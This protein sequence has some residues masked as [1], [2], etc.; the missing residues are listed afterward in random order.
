M[1]QDRTL[2]FLADPATH[3]LPPGASVKIIETHVSWVF[4]AGEQAFKLKKQVRFPYLD[5]TGL[6]DRQR[7]CEAELRINR[8]TAPDLYLGLRRVTETTEGALE[9]DGAGPVVDWLVG[10]RRFAD[11]A[12]FIDLAADGRLRRRLTEDLAD[13]IAEFHGAADYSPEWGGSTRIRAIVDNNDTSFRQLAEG[14]LAACFTP[15]AIDQLTAG[16]RVWLERVS[17]LLDAR[18]DAGR[19]RHCHGDLHLANICLYEGRPTPF[20][21]IEFSDLFARIDVFYD[22]AFLLMDLDHRGFRRLAAFVL[23]RYLDQGGPP[24]DPDAGDARPGD[25][26]AGLAALP[27]FLSMRAAV[28]AHVSGAQAAGLADPATRAGRQAEAGAYF[29]RALSYLDVPAPRLVAVGGLSGSGKSRLARELASHLGAAPGARVVRSD[30]T[31]KRL[32]GIDIQDRLAPEF[33]TPEWSARTYRACF[34]EI[35]TALTAGRA[36]V[37][38]AVQAKPEERAMIAGLARDAGVPFD[39]IWVSAP[40]DVRLRR[41]ADRQANVSDV[42][43]EVARGQEDYD[44]GDVGWSEVSSTGAKQETVDQGLTLLGLPV[45]DASGVS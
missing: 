29:A 21:A 26:V 1:P 25:D 6:A 20:D 31:R 10:M 42:T 34:A 40:L 9:L 16:S 2:A 35:R 36:A 18:R 4:L 41:I 43:P 15:G 37:F 14:P 23:N 7:A 3:G 30:V 44:L 24:P 45:S 33:Y 13:A 28:R 12:L 32:A 11:D 22:L 19:V 39:G 5:F 27:L 17:D 38:D 8:R